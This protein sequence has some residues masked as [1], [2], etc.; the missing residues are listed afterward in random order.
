[1]LFSQIN[2]LWT[3]FAV[4]INRYCDISSCCFHWQFIAVLLTVSLLYNCNMVAIHAVALFVYHC[5]YVDCYFLSVRI[6]LFQQTLLTIIFV[7]IAS[8][9][10]FFVC[11]M[12]FFLSVQTTDSGVV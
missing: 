4:T 5:S 7:N 11:R 10:V 3:V 1:M 9:G 12:R 2:V 6:C 8:V